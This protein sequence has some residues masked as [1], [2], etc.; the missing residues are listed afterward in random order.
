MKKVSIKILKKKSFQNE[1][2]YYNL[3]INRLIS[4]QCC[5]QNAIRFETSK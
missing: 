5:S 4:F 1:A 3:F 2:L